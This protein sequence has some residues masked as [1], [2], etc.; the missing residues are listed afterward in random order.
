VPNVKGSALASRLLWVRLGHGEAGLE[1]LARAASPALA[2]ALTEGVAM[3][4][5]YPFEVF[6]ELNQVMDRLFGSGDLALVW[7][8]GRFGADANLK[9]VYRLFYKVG[10]VRW[11]LGRA[12]RLWGAHYDSGELVLIDDRPGYGKLEIVDFATPHR[13]HCLSVGGWC[14]RSVEISG[15]REARVRELE[16][17]ARGEARCLLEATWT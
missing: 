16:C 13:T 12:A 6:V 9:T 14:E 2:T 15:G 17:R 7:Q 1:E 5:W 10:T 11:I 8:L 3:A 4:R